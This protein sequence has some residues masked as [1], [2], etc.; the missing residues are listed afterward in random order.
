MNSRTGLQGNLLNL[1]AHLVGKGSWNQRLAA[2]VGVFGVVVIPIGIKADFAHH[3]CL[4]LLPSEYGA[5][6]WATVQQSEFS[7]NS[8]EYGTVISLWSYS[9]GEAAIA[10]VNSTFGMN[11]GAFSGGPVGITSRART[12]VVSNS[13]FVGNT[14]WGGAAAYQTAGSAYLANCI[15]GLVTSSSTNVVAEDAE[16]TFVDGERGN[17]HLAAQSPCID[18]GSNLV[19]WEALVPGFQLIPATDLDGNPRVLDGDGDGEA[20]VDMGA[21]EFQGD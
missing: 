13:V 20:V 12:A 11:V 14:E 21:Y 10:V 7:H 5:F 15:E 18:G 17:L 16:E 3:R 2:A 4:E 1:G 9:V 19:D 6:Q 8:S